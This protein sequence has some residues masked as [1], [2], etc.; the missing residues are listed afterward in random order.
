MS[1]VAE[2]YREDAEDAVRIV[3]A[4]LRRGEGGEAFRER[5]RRFSWT[6]T[7]AGL[8]APAFAEE[9]GTAVRLRRGRESLLVACDGDGPEALREAARA[10]AR[11]AGGSPFLKSRGPARAPAGAETSAVDEEERAAQLGAALH[12][13]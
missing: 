12:R 5:R 3:S 1:D 11:R 13:A 6:A 4:L 9:R 7:E 8:L 10:A 2:A